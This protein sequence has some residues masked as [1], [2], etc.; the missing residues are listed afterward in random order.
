MQNCRATTQDVDRVFSGL[1][2]RIGAEFHRWGETHGR[3]VQEVK[4]TFQKAAD[5]GASDALSDEGRL[6]AVIMWEVRGSDIILSFA[7]SEA[8][9]AARHVRPF[10]R[11][12]R[13][14][15]AWQ[16]NRT[17]IAVSWTRQP[18]VQRWFEAL[19]G[20]LIEETDDSRVFHLP[21]IG[22]S[23]VSTAY[24]CQIGGSNVLWW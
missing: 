16:G 3:P 12:L 15:Q 11:Y 17:L 21:A 18:V 2:D 1:A 19:G 13:D 10:K 9:F 8:F 4:T 20:H 23:P 24:T 14:L 6:L 7:A 22:E 5:R